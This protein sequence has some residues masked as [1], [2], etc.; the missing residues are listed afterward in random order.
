[1]LNM[2]YVAETAVFILLGFSECPKF[3]PIYFLIRK[4]VGIHMSMY[5]CV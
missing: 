1:M 4:K 3:I 5:V 2:F